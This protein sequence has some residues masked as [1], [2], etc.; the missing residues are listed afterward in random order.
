ME[1]MLENSHNMRERILPHMG[2]R[3]E[4]EGNVGC[5]RDTQD[6]ANTGGGTDG[7]RLSFAWGCRAPTFPLGP[8]MGTAGLNTYATVHGP[9]GGG[10]VGD[11]K[12]I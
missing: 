3:G 6:S 12:I 8:T 4:R 2:N 9:H 10:P 5:R 11:S 1:L 7:A